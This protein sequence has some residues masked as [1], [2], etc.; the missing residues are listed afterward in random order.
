MHIR[1]AMRPNGS[2][3]IHT[4]NRNFVLE[5]MKANN[6]I[7]KQFP[8]HIAVRT[9][10]A[11]VQLLE[12]AGFHVNNVRYLS[13]YLALL[14]PFHLLSWLPGVGINFSARLFIHAEWKG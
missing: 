8:E 7:I 12:A 10:S 11:N 2:L 6:L 13:H 9:A 3:Y 14:K 1:E 5:R 4:P